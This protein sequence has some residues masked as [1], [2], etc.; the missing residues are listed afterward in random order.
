MPAPPAATTPML[1]VGDVLLDVGGGAP[2]PARTRGAP[3]RAA[4]PGE[5][6]PGAQGDSRAVTAAEDERQRPHRPRAAEHRDAP[7]G[8]DLALRPVDDEVHR[9]AEARPAVHAD[10]ASQY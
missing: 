2:Q 8:R 1:M 5:R 7:A 10:E 3:D 4:T 9:L 6:K